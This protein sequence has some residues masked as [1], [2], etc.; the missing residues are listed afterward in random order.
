MFSFGGP[1]FKKNPYIVIDDHSYD[2]YHINGIIDLT[3]RKIGG[4]SF[5]HTLFEVSAEFGYVW[6]FMSH[7]PSLLISFISQYG[8]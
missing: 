6:D 8:N 4:S 1:T 2:G 3:D 5:V 7:F